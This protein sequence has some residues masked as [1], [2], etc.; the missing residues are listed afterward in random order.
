MSQQLTT[1]TPAQDASE[2]TDTDTFPYAGER[3][4]TNSRTAAVGP[5]VCPDCGGTTTAVHGLSDCPDCDW[6]G[7]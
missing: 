6:T 7:N 2:A 1:P 3:T 5:T 4:G